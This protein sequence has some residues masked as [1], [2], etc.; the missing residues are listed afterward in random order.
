MTK[1]FY[2]NTLPLNAA[3]LLDKFQNS[4]LS[5]L[6]SFY[7]SGGTALSLQLGHRESEDLDFFSPS[8]FSPQDVEK[9]LTQFGDLSDTEMANGTLNT[10]L[11]GVK[12]QFLEY[13]Y[14]L[15]ESLVMW[16]EIQLSSVLDIG[17]TKLQTIGMRGSKK[18]F[19]DLYFIFEQYSLPRLLEEVRKK[20]SHV[21]YSQTHILKSLVFFVEA[22]DQPSPRMH[23]EVSFEEVKEKM[24]AEVRAISFE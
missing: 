8:E 11:S 12:L 15:L 13:P 23:K 20:Y 6:E 9:E 24:I 7:L 2:T 3:K 19:I 4:N 16:Q 18:D 21:D 22:E 14:P 10:F 5:F 17:C 1:L